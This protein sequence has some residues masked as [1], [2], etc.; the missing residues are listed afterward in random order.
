MGMILWIAVCSAAICLLLYREQKLTERLNDAFLRID[1]IANNEYART[2]IN[3]VHGVLD[4]H[5]ERL[6]RIETTHGRVISALTQNVE[7]K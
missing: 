2:R 1:S 3:T 5:A 7:A 6:Y 4:S